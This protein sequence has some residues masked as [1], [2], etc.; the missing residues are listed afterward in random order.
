MLCI[1][2]VH[3]LPEI[4]E[5]VVVEVG[6]SH[7]PVNALI[8]DEDTEE[9]QSEQDHGS[10][11]GLVDGGDTKGMEED[12]GRLAIADMGEK[13]VRVAAA[14]KFREVDIKDCAMVK[15]TLDG[16]RGVD[17]EV[18]TTR[19]TLFVKDE[20]RNIDTEVWK[21]GKTIRARNI[22]AAVYKAGKTLYMT[23]ENRDIDTKVYKT[24]KTPDMSKEQQNTDTDVEMTGISNEEENKLCRMGPSDMHMAEVGN[25]LE[26]ESGA[27][28][29][30]QPR[31]KLAEFVV[32]KGLSGLSGA[33]VRA[34]RKMIVAGHILEEGEIVAY[35]EDDTTDGGVLERCKSRAATEMEHTPL[36][37][38]PDAD[39]YY[40]DRQEGEEEERDRKVV[41]KYMSGLTPTV[42][43]ITDESSTH[44]IPV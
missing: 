16:H 15:K 40:N 42:P 4:S 13:S 12:V 43:E 23:D 18:D 37:S 32:R 1:D 41:E 22:E 28:V 19:K 44:P 11:P 30:V 5:E 8:T 39:L 36:E 10:G 20:Q 31:L 25:S 26:L 33:A 2:D 29:T 27:K 24:G 17:T 14:D 7:A 34:A 21:T 3:V 38:D 9:I 35:V 6:E